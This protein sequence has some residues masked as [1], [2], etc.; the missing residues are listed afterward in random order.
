[1]GLKQKLLV[2]G[3]VIAIGLGAILGA[4]ALRPQPQLPTFEEWRQT[5]ITKREKAVKVIDYL[6]TD[7]KL[8]SLERDLA[9]TNLQIKI[10]KAQDKIYDLQDTL[11]NTNYQGK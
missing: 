6:I 5:E 1:M 11:R 7:T 8:R 9:S 10:L 2:Y 4:D 3:G